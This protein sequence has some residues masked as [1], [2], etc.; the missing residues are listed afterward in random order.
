MIA[1]PDFTVSSNIVD[2]INREI[3]PGTVEVMGGTISQLKRAADAPLENQD[4]ILPGFIDS[5]VH[6]EN[7]MLTPTEFARAAAV[8]G[9]VAVVSDPH[10]IANVL[11]MQGV[12][13]MVESGA[14]SSLK[15]LFG[16]PSCVPATP[17]E[18]SG[19][20][21]GISTEDMLE[22]EEIGYLAEMMNFPGVI[23]KDPVVMGKIA[24]AKL[25]PFNMS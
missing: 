24:A 4:Y 12:K 20:T 16:A 23:N 25:Y 21:L 9:T 19:A 22:Y 7:S 18:T 6:I 10:E 2:I 13:Y 15:F 5:H 3:Y 17:F 8:H 14:Q 11:G 1:M